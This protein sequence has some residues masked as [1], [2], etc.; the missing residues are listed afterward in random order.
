MLD[1]E[2]LRKY[3]KPVAVLDSCKGAECEKEK[4]EEKG[5]EEGE[6]LDAAGLAAAH[7]AN[8]VAIDAASIIQAWAEVDELEEG[9]TYAD[10]LQEMFFEGADE[11]GD[12]ELSDTDTVL[13]EASLNAA[14]DYLLS[15]GVNEE[16]AYKLLSEWNADAAERVHDLIVEK[17]PD[18]DAADADIDAFVFGPEA[19][20]AVMDNVYAKKTVVYKGKVIRNKRIKI[21]GAIDHQRSATTKKNSNKMHSSAAKAKWRKSM[22][23]RAARGLNRHH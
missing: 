7:A 1:T 9:E 11:N 8:Q 17:L 3:A 6:A 18:G 15:K 20:G 14:Y 13:I 2:L 22:R 4:A 16:D 19:E 12:G 5:G 10:V 23:L 21:G